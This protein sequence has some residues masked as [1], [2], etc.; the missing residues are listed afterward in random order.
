[1]ICFPLHCLKGSGKTFVALLIA[2]NHLQN[3]PPGQ[4]GKIAFLV[5]KIPVYEQQ[6]NVFKQ[7][8]ETKK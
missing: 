1:M 4:K 7:H 6:R 3:M 5:T 8:F 2:E